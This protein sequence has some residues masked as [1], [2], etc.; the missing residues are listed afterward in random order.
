LNMARDHFQFFGGARLCEP[1]Q[2]CIFKALKFS[3]RFCL[4]KLLWV[5][6]P[7]SA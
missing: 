7:R 1:Q 4:A 6:D 2:G 3:K 5:T